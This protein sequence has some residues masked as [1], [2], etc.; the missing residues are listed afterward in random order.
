MTHTDPRNK[1]RGFFYL[2]INV[3][4]HNKLEA[5]SQKLVANL[6]DGKNTRNNHN[7]STT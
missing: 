1:I 5:R 6:K 7:R 2:S 3:T 4:Q